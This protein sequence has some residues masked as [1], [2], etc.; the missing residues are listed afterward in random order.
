MS[1]SGIPNPYDSIL[2]AI[3]GIGVNVGVGVGGI[4]VPSTQGDP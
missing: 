3:H 4:Q 2:Y 1:S